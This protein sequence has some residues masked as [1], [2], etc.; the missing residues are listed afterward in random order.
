LGWR[1]EFIKR[2]DG[3]QI[4]IKARAVKQ[5]VE[6]NSVAEHDHERESKLLIAFCSTESSI[7]NEPTSETSADMARE[8]IKATLT[9]SGMGRLRARL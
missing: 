7:I 8:F 3:P 9:E 4:E 2:L 1:Q 6:A 5:D